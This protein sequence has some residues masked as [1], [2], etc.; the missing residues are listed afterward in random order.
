MIFQFMYIHYNFKCTWSEKFQP[1][2]CRIYLNFNFT[3]SFI[4]IERLNDLE[5]NDK[6]YQN[7]VLSLSGWRLVV[8]R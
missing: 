7:V 1:D 3:F 4:S 2:F 5:T 6:P 8:L